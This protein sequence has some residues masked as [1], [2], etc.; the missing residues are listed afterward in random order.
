MAESGLIP[1][2]MVE[3]YKYISSKY[4]AM[5]GVGSG[6]FLMDNIGQHGENLTIAVLSMNRSSL[7]VRLM[8]SVAKEIP[9]FAG[10]FLIGDNGSEETEKVILRQAMRNM[11]YRC[12]M[13]EFDRNYGVGGIGCSKQ[14]KQSGYWQWIMIHTLCKIH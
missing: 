12:R 2:F 6:P 8:E 9:D 1:G 11:P 3:E 4:H 5:I 10:E 13:V 7:T 14:L